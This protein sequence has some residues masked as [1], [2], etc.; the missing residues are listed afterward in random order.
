LASL[1]ENTEE[2]FE[3]IKRIEQRQRISQI[4]S[5]YLLIFPALFFCW[6]A[7]LT[8]LTRVLPSFDPYYWAGITFSFGYTLFVALAYCKAILSESVSRRI[9]AISRMSL[10]LTW[11]IAV[12]IINIALLLSSYFF[13]FEAGSS[14]VFMFA[15]MWGSLEIAVY[16][17]YRLVCGKVIP[18][19]KK[20]LIISQEIE[21]VEE[22]LGRREKREARMIPYAIAT[23]T[24]GFYAL[25]MKDDY[26][27]F[28]LVFFGS[29]ALG[30]VL[31]ELYRLVRK[32]LM[33]K[34]I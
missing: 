23:Y 24:L 20:R 29:A 31:L 22:E 27:A 34:A 6:G 12:L 5:L 10:A 15:L 18:A 30:S 25:F 1:E 17:R 33:V 21:G 4:D 7:S 32:R 2:L 19:F 9:Y 26:W 3:V 14:R 16:T 13:G 8:L 28:L 11:G